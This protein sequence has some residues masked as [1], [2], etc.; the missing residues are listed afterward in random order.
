MNETDPAHAGF[1]LPAA[2]DVSPLKLRSKIVANHEN[3][4]HKVNR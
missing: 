3:N 1:Q 2:A 4:R